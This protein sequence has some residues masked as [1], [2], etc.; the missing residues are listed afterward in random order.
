MNDRGGGD[1]WDG[2]EEGW[3]SDATGGEDSDAAPCPGCA[4]LPDAAPLAITITMR[5]VTNLLLYIGGI[6]NILLLCKMTGVQLSL[7]CI[8]TMF[9]GLGSRL[10]NEGAVRR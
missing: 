9:R 1:G 8:I 3:D 5:D 7:L 4:P 2:L 10:Q 6:Q